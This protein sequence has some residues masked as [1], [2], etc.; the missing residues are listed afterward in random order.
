MAKQKNTELNFLY[1]D[2]ENKEKKVKNQNKRNRNNSKN[3]KRKVGAD[4][5]S[6]QNSTT[7]NFDNEIVIG[8]TKIP[9]KNKRNQNNAKNGKRKVGTGHVSAQNSNKKKKIEA[10]RVSVS[11]S[12][13]KRKN[14]VKGTIKW[15]FLL[16]ALIAS[17]VF[18]MMSPLFNLATIQVVNNE[19]IS[20]DTIVS[21][22]GLKLGENIYKTNR[23]QI[24][25]NIKQNAYIESVNI[26]RQLPNKILITVKERKA[27]YML[28]YANSYAY[29]NNQGYILEISEEKLNVPIIIGYTTNQ[30]EIKIGNRIN[31][32]D[33]EKLAT[34]L[35]IVESANVN[36]IGELIT[37]INIQNKQDYALVLEKEKKTVYLGDASDLSNRMLYI[38]AILEQEKGIEGEIFINKDLNKEDVY[39][40]MK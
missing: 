6:A 29:I 20:S 24:E 25:K 16:S 12:N 17:F 35:K 3:R 28:E 21:L 15:I 9:E 8:V 4:P 2:E 14:I 26:N 40:R 13:K 1:M 34:V 22:S 32:E 11:N 36:G 18:F 10:N 30:E 37:K 23:K 7:F 39:F 31:D 19:K 38:K 27:T 33:L 5:M